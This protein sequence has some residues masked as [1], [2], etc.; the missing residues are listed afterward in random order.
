M[1]PLVWFRSDLRTAD[2][3]ALH[4]ACAE[5]TRGVV[6][7]FLVAPDQWRAHDWADARV[8]FVLR[9]LV[10]LRGALDRLRV[11]LLVETAPGF[12]DAPDALVRLARRHACDGVFFNREYEVNERARDRVVVAR[13]EREGLEA[14]AFTDQVILPPGSVRTGKGDFYTVFTPF[15]KAWC[16]RVTEQGVPKPLAR[17]WPHLRSRTP[18][19]CS[20]SRSR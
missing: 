11:P 8:D 13:F 6:A 14:R 10:E 18:Q 20:P 12:D 16:A 1:R 15:R 4:A 5:A 19:S 9:T 7:V 17:P 2:H 3:P